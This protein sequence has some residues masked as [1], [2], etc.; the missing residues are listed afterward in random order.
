[1]LIIGAKG[2][3][4]EL[5]EIVHQKDVL[6]NLAFYDD[7]STNIGTHL[8]DKFPVLRTEE[9][10]KAYFESIANDYVIGI[11]NPNL[12]F[13]MYSKFSKLNGLLISLISPFCRIGSYNVDIGQG[14]I[15]M[16]NAIISNNVKIGSGCLIYY[17]ATIT[18]DCKIGDFVELSPSANILGNVT[19]GSLTHVGANATILPKV[20]IG[21]NVVVGAGAVVTKD[22]PDNC[23]VVGIPAKIVK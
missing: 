14:T 8:F 21:K 7:V 17:N 11:G 19:I 10:A 9:Q 16:D 18:H 1:M 22:I 2:L 20:K 13:K 6:S 23:T 3:A 4:G 15:I 12:R 5:L